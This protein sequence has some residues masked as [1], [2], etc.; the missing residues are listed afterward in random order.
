M[1]EYKSIQQFAVLMEGRQQIVDA[2][3]Y[4]PEIF[5]SDCT[6]DRNDLIE[7]L[8]MLFRN[9][10]PTKGLESKGRRPR[11]Q[12]Q[13]ECISDLMEIVRNYMTAYGETFRCPQPVFFDKER[14]RLNQI[15]PDN[16]WP[17]LYPIGFSDGLPKFR[18][19]SRN[20]H[21]EAISTSSLAWPE[22]RVYNIAYMADDYSA[23]YIRASETEMIKIT[24]DDFEL[25]PLGTD[26]VLV[27]SSNMAD[28]PPMEDLRDHV[29]TLRETL[30][31]SIT[32]LVPGTALT[33][34]FKTRFATDDLLTP[35][36]AQRI[37]LT[38][39]LFMFVSAQHPLLWP[40]PA[41]TGDTGTGKSTPFELQNVIFR[42]SR[43]KAELDALP[44]KMRDFIA[45][46]TKSEYCALD[47]VDNAF[48]K[49]PPEVQNVLCQTSSGGK[50]SLAALYET[51]TKRDKLQTHV[52]LTARDMPFDREDVLR[53]VIHL[54]TASGVGEE[55]KTRL[56][57]A[58]AKR[59]TE[60]IAE[61]L[62]RCQNMVRAHK[63]NA[64]KRYP[65]QSRMREYEFFTLLCAD[66]EGMLQETVDLWAAYVGTYHA[67]ITQDNGLLT[68]ILL[69]IGQDPE[70][71]KGSYFTDTLHKHLLD[72]H[73]K[74]GIEFPYRANTSFGRA[75]T[76]NLVAL[77]IEAGLQDGTD[78]VRK[79]RLIS[80]NMPP[81]RLETAA[82]M[83]RDLVANPG[84]P[85]ALKDLFTA[86]RARTGTRGAK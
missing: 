66:Y 24:E 23:I 56:L 21:Q 39:L 14:C 80:F 31:D 74:I 13:E 1:P 28:L 9:E 86:N 45:Y 5:T 12:S 6:L 8:K 44:T 85:S 3:I 42:G 62:V 36:Q 81:D 77:K 61:I 19:V 37:L 84:R 49:S 55:V 30:G 68:S 47:N 34:L 71:V 70:R 15:E 72:L 67:S 46:L 83:Y 41:I 53:R 10:N 33:D 29:V 63:A 73:K 64:D 54:R 48:A 2:A 17:I 50:I 78:P 60:I 18:I 59:R 7:V 69:W 20:L 52:F 65:L 11:Y 35:Q 82:A 32:R 22:R 27:K 57:D 25:V 16:A 76:D 58:V 4:S 75:L 51:N 40:L 26:G 43:D 79:R 38:R